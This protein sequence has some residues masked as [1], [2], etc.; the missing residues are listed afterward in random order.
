V[1]APVVVGQALPEPA[2]E[3][4]PLPPV[5]TSSSHPVLDPHV[6]SARRPESSGPPWLV[7]FGVVTA[8]LAGAGVW[9]AF[10]APEETPV[11][12]PPVVVKPVE[13]PPVVVKPV[14]PP[15]EPPV[16][17][18]PVEPPVEP[19][20]PP[21]VEKTP[22]VVRPKVEV[23]SVDALRSR[24]RSL[25]RALVKATPKGTEPDPSALGFLEKR[26]ARLSL[27]PSSRERARISKD[28]DEWEQTFL[29]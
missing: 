2:A 19:V 16:V 26:K 18:K 29:R 5:R 7:I 24:V 10:R 20:E 11:D 15:V 17:V 1:A 23:P 28:L 21:H 8:A 12:A 14:E 25:E 4:A 27:A 13:P 6:R 9:W 3:A 22:K